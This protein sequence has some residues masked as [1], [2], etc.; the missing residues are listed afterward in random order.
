[1]NKTPVNYDFYM[2]PVYTSKRVKLR[3]IKAGQIFISPTV[4]DEVCL[5]KTTADG[6]RVKLIID[7]DLIT[8]SSIPATHD[9]SKEVLTFHELNGA[10]LKAMMLK[11]N[12]A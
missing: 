5:S 1:M 10:N 11:F 2:E 8:Y 6:T 7:D 4:E 12:E 9:R 3:T